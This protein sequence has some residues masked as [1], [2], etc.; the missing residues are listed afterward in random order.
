M[1]RPGR[2]LVE[3]VELTAGTGRDFVVAGRSRLELFSARLVTGSD[4]LDVAWI[5]SLSLGTVVKRLAQV[6]ELAGGPGSFTRLRGMA[7]DNLQALIEA[8]HFYT[9][10]AS[11]ALALALG[12]RWRVDVMPRP[13]TSTWDITATRLGD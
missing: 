13:H 2:M 8:G 1:A 11:Q 10:K 9:Q 3:Q 5:A 7:S 4:T 6:Q 12:G